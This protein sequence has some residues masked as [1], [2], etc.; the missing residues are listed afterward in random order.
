MA[1]WLGGSRSV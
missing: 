1:T